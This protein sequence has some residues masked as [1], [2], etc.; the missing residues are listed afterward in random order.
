MEDLDLYGVVR[1][2]HV[3]SHL[4]DIEKEASALLTPHQQIAGQSKAKSLLDGKLILESF[5]DYLRDNGADKFEEFV[6]STVLRLVSTVHPNETERHTNLMHYASILDKYIDWK[7]NL[8]SLHELSPNASEYRIIRE[9]LNQ[10]RREIKAEIEGVWQSDQLRTNPIPVVSEAARVLDRY[11]MIFKAYP[12]FL[13]FVKFL[14]KEAFWLYQA[15]HYA[16][17]KEDWMSTFFKVRSKSSESRSGKVKSIKRTFRELNIKLKPPSITAPIITFGTWKGGDRDGNPFVVASFTN[18]TFVDQ[19]V[20]VLE[21]YVQM[22]SELLDKLTSATAHVPVTKELQDSVLADALVF[23]YLEN[24]KTHEPYRSK[25]RYI[26]EKLRNTY[27]RVVEV[28][29]R[30]GETVKPLLGLTLPGPTGYNYAWQLQKDIDTL[31][32]SFLQ[33]N[34]KAQGRSLLQDLKI[35]IDTFGLHMAAID[36]RQTS[37]KNL[38]ALRE[39]LEFINH[40]SAKN[41]TKLSE[42][43]K[44]EC[45]LGLLQ[46][47]D[48]LMTSWALQSLSKI[49]RDTI[50]TLFI[51]ADVAKTDPNAVGKFIISMCSGVSDILVL[52]FLM[53][54]AGMCEIKEGRITRFPFD[55]TGLFETIQDLKACPRIIKQALSLPLYRNY[56]TE[57]RGGRI[58]VMLGYSDS[59][60][61]GSCL[62][63]DAQ[64]AHTA[65]AIK[66]LEDEINMG[67]GKEGESNQRISF[68]F[69]RGRGDTLPRGYGGSI[70]KSI[71]S[72]S[73]T[74]GSE[75]HTEQNR[76]LR[77]YSSVASAVDHFHKIY[78]A[79]VGAQLAVVAKPDKSRGG[80]YMFPEENALYQ[81]YMDF[82]GKISYVTWNKLVNPEFGPSGEVYFRIL[83]TYSILPHLASCHFASRPV[84][85]EGMTYNIDTIRAIPFAMLLAQMREFTV[86]YYGTGTSYQLASEWLQQPSTTVPLLVKAWARNNKDQKDLP[87]AFAKFTELSQLVEAY[88]MSKDVSELLAAGTA[89]ESTSG[90]YT[91][92]LFDV[93]KQYNSVDEGIAYV[94]T[95]MNDVAKNRNNE[96]LTILQEMYYSYAPFRYST[97]N[98]EASLLV[99]DFRM[100]QTYTKDASAEEKAILEYTE[101][102]AVLATRWVLAI[103]KQTQLS[104]KTMLQDWRSPELYL[105]HKIQSRFL[106]RYREIE[107]AR[108][109]TGGQRPRAE[110]ESLDRLRVYIQLTVL[111]VS[112][113]LGFGG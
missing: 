45:L 35:L 53:K 81:K 4:A 113:A 66:E 39:Y 26:L 98:K 16:S 31:R 68:V 73:V 94:A 82:F 64:V 38:D 108:K 97:E 22:A 40:P 52:L 75:D 14:A 42:N 63:S 55:I 104:S 15:Y 110:L 89:D 49:T 8:Q 86:A 92:S 84:A 18:Q 85:R 17:T 48:M 88:G 57:H 9:S 36:F 106:Q 103:S 46:E 47:P 71:A 69:Y 107:S 44:I 3:R 29:Q 25:M 60:R 83:N 58:T 7:K 50:E 30:A 24:I 41:L 13:K 76:Y 43:E 12:I 61:E 1:D 79:H 101:A 93:L 112:E 77:V 32:N 37:T 2:L 87:A 96:L 78:R 56:V 6:N 99:R 109:K 100:V 72:Q 34:G 67:L 28:R 80:I 27:T 62:A 91:P 54:L 59:A 74:S 111:A 70:S 21:H 65:L 51:F 20:Y 95:L 23:P 33:H 90:L 5:L 105:L 10:T 102:E 19:K 11:A